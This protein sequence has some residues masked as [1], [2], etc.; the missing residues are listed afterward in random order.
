MADK[1]DEFLKKLEAGDIMY[2]EIPER[3]RKKTLELLTSP[4]NIK[5]TLDTLVAAAKSKKID[6]R[7]SAASILDEIGEKK[8]MKAIEEVAKFWMPFLDM[9]YGGK[10]VGDSLEGGVELN[11]RQA[12]EIFERMRWPPAA[13]HEALV[14]EKGLKGI[15]FVELS[16]ICNVIA[17]G[18]SEKHEQP[19]LKA[20][21]DVI[22]KRGDVG[23]FFDAM[24]A[25]GTEDSK[26]LLEEWVDGNAHRRDDHAIYHLE[27]ALQALQKLDKR[28]GVSS[29]PAEDA[30]KEAIARVEA[31]SNKMLA[32]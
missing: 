16:A 1:A 12:V 19:L 28:L 7:E 9:K 13:D 5:K 21:R 15:D 30:L 29:K 32:Q 8:A 2:Y 22:K 11:K 26:K 23:A 20:A 10:V 4:E 27:D 25:V 14:L 6:A 24:G 17:H 18:G 3:E 31:R